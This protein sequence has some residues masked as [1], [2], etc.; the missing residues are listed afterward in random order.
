MA[1]KCKQKLAE[2]AHISV[3]Y[4]ILRIFCVS[5]RVSRVG[6]FKYTIG[7]FKKKIKISQN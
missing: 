1:T 4:K 6:E 7:I 5:R 3:P 2:I